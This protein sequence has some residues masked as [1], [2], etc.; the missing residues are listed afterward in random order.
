MPARLTVD[1]VNYLKTAVAERFTLE[2]GKASWKSAGEQ[3]ETTVAGPAFYVPAEGAPEIIAVLARALLAAPGG[4]LPLLPA[5]EAAIEK[6]GPLTVT[7]GGRSRTVVQYAIT[8]LG[9]SPTPVWLDE[10]GAFFAQH[11]GWPVAI[12]AGWEAAIPQLEAAQDQ[13][14]KARELELARRL[15]RRPPGGVVVTGARLFDPAT[16]TVT[17]GT[18]VVVARQPG[19][20]GGAGRHASRFR[21]GRE[22]IDA[23]GK[24]LLPGLWDMHTHVSARRTGS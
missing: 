7:A 8:G 11:G 24:M 5:G 22:V 18:T 6:R 3:G 2:G 23:A 13:A 17:P 16:G 19:A 15:T 14:E 21:A 9:F 1:G 4:R 10:D 20:G 12:R